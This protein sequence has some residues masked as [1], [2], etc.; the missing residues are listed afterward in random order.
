MFK[1][2]FN[3]QP[4]R[5]GQRLTLRRIAPH[6]RQAPGKRRAPGLPPR[7]DVLKPSQRKRVIPRDRL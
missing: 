5:R 3:R 1:R 7:P 4:R 6:E 2:L